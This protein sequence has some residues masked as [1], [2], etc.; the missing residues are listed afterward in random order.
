M[1]APAQSDYKVRVPFTIAG[2]P[3]AKVM[4]VTATDAYAAGDQA[5]AFCVGAYDFNFDRDGVVAVAI[6]PKGA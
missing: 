5:Y 4:R 6:D 1:S 2:Q 3:Y